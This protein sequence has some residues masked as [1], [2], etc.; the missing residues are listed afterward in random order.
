MRSARSKEREREKTRFEYF[1]LIKI[2]MI[3]RVVFFINARNKKQNVESKL[4]KMR[5]N[6][7]L[8]GMQSAD[9]CFSESCTGAD[10]G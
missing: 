8:N 6:L 1:M 10:N 7:C 3:Q 2:K 4:R 9:V 5:Q